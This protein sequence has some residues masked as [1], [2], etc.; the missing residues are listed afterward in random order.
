MVNEHYPDSSSEHLRRRRCHRVPEPRFHF[1]GARTSG[2]VSRVRVPAKAVPELF[3]YG[4]YTIPEIS[5]VGKNEEELTQA[6]V[7][8]E[9]GKAR[10]REIARGQIHRRFTGLAEDHLPDRYPRVAREYILSA[11][12]RANWCI[13]DR[14][15]W[16]RRQDRLLHQHVFNY[17]TLA[18]CYKT[19]A[20]D[21]I[22]RMGLHPEE[23][24][25]LTFPV[26]PANA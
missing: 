16:L 5:M 13:S 18:E 3:P 10:Y 21:G 7:P 22:N 24:D 15:C 20:F 25:P 11:R 14:P 12:D 9:V 1:D 2:R 23:T 17:P 8:Y 26:N 19:A 6:G 4:I